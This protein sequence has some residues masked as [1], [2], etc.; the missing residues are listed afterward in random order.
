[1]DPPNRSN[2]LSSQRYLLPW[3]RS[4]EPIRVSVVHVLRQALNMIGVRYAPRTINNRRFMVPLETRGLR[5]LIATDDI[6]FLHDAEGDYYRRV[7]DLVQ[8]GFSIFD[9]GAHFGLYTLAFVEA[10]GDL[11]RVI[12]FEPNPASFDIL[13][14]TIAINELSNIVP[15]QAAISDQVGRSEFQVTGEPAESHLRDANSQHRQAKECF[16]VDVTTIDEFAANSGYL[17]DLIKIDVEGSEVAVLRGAA[18]TLKAQRPV[19]CCEIHES[20]G[21]GNDGSVVDI[22]QVL[23][24]L[25]YQVAFTSVFSRGQRNIYIPA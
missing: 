12:S 18:D 15:I 17:P 11:G 24:D 3:L 1:M 6:D 23:R 22:E 2:N 19:L 8:P 25:E 21:G 10:V 7:V 16:E 20:V 5:S 14:R 4:L 9:V 13:T